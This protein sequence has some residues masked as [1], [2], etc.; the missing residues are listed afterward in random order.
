MITLLL[1]AALAAPPATWLEAWDALLTEATDGH[2]GGSLDTLRRLAT[3]DVPADDPTLPLV[4]YWLGH[5]AWQVG[6]ADG[7][8]DALDAC[9]RAGIDKAR[10][11]DLRSRIDL[12]MDAVATIPT[13]WSFDDADHGFI[14]PRP[15]WDRGSIRIVQTESGGVLA[16]TTQI[17]AAREDQLVVGFRA[18]APEPHTVTVIARSLEMDATLALV[19]QDEEGHEYASPQRTWWLQQGERE[20]LMVR[21]ADLVPLVPGSPPASGAGLHRLFL[22]DET[23]LSGQIGQNVLHIDEFIV[24]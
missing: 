4:Q 23:G 15:F 7:A 10:C 16:W 22:R 21:I 5:A 14:H 19:F 3:T 13:R 11:L 1:G 2:N 6:D 20:V 12:E 8:R 18:P 24:Q 17:D 9:I